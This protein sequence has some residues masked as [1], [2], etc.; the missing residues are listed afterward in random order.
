MTDNKFT[1]NGNDSNR[2][3]SRTAKIIVEVFRLPTV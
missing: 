2:D 1:N 3:N